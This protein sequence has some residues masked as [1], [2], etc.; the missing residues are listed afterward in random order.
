MTHE[1][2]LHGQARAVPLRHIA[3]PV[4]RAS[5]SGRFERASMLECST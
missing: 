5:L 1:I 2:A 4:D 3:P